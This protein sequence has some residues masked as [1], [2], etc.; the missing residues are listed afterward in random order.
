MWLAFYT[1]C[2]KRLLVEHLTL[3]LES[4]ED[5]VLSCFSISLVFNT[6]MDFNQFEPFV[7]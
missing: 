6:D 4:P 5:N 2:P 7:K 1:R 3:K